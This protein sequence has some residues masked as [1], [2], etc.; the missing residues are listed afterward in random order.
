MS[1]TNMGTIES[2]N[3]IN[4][5][6]NESASYWNNEQETGNVQCHENSET[7]LIANPETIE[8]SNK[9]STLIRLIEY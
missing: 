9:K 2:V 4:E 1:N 7:V 6:R 8:D 5:C 3:K